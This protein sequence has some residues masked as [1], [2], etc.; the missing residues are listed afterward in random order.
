MTAA[1]W[2]GSIRAGGSR[3]T[4]RWSAPTCRARTCAN[5][6]SGVPRQSSARKVSACAAKSTAKERTGPAPE[7]SR[8]PAA[9]AVIDAGV[10]AA[11]EQGAQGYVGDQLPGDDV[12]EQFAHVADGGVEV[13]GVLLGLQRP[14]AAQPLPLRPHPQGV[15]G[16][17]FAHPAVD[18]VAGGLGEGQEFGH[19]LGVD[20]RAVPRGWA[21]IALGSDPKSDAVGQ[22]VVV[23]RLDA[24]P[25][26]DEQ[27]FLACGRP[28]ARRRTCR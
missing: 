12:V 6:V 27:Q 19:A 17:E 8:C 15:A 23:E 7:R 9:S 13:V 16:A 3:M 10:Q 11:G 4:T 22:R 28:T 20:A 21:R 25:V 26:A 24:H 2:A 5:G 18:G 1:R 14:V